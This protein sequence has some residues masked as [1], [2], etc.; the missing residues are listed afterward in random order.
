MLY[1]NIC[2]K[3]V[4]PNP[5]WH[6][7][8]FSKMINTILLCLV[9]IPFL[10]AFLLPLA[11]IISKHLRNLLALFLV[12][13]A[14]FCSLALIPFALKGNFASICQV[15][16]LGF[17]LILRADALAVFMACIS[18][19]VSAIIVFYSFSYIDHYDNQNE[20]Y[21]MVV[22]FVGS[23]MGLVFSQNL[24]WL[25]LFWE[26]TAFCS[27]RLIGFFR[28]E[29]QVFKADKAFLITVLG[30][31]LMLLGF[32]MLHQT[33]GSFDLSVIKNF[34]ASNLTIALILAGIFAK[35]ATLP[36]Q[37]WLPDAGVAPSP[38]TALLHAA[39]LVKIG[40]Y[41]FARIFIVT[42]PL[43]LF[44]QEAV[45]IIAGLSALVAAGA[46]L[47]ETDLKR[48]IAYSTIS[49]IG[50]IFLGFSM[51][52]V[53]G[54]AGSLLYILMHGLAKGGLFLCAGIVEH[55]AKTKNITQ[56]GGLF[57][58]MP[59]TAFS[60]LVCAFSVMGIPPLG[61]FF[62]KYLVIVSALQGRRFYLAVLF[63]GIAFLTI[64]YL[65]RVFNLVF[66]GELK[67]PGIKEGFSTMVISV[68]WLA[69][70]SL[71][72]GIFISGPA[73]LALIA[74]QQML[75]PLK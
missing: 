61:G 41:A 47:V 4:N 38:V 24:I 26:I 62:A 30:S 9:L 13:T 18:S 7:W 44:W 59:I 34:P 48:L 73:N 46:A 25:Y 72:A 58:V 32:L 49:Q 3:G 53:F 35:S 74:A 64:I 1:N 20:Y 8:Q 27:W 65:L 51:G 69:G 50:F 75:G 17:N 70:L 16:P 12:L 60:F 19:L 52:N 31:L 71:L 39:V 10:G 21:L 45:P 36:F 54:V 67:Y 68:V 5:F 63:L 15:L 28:G 42:L 22:L 6:N 40:V 66:M 11:G 29:N 23:M 2:W 43:T 33:A 56:L 55:N 57:Y 14:L 37:T